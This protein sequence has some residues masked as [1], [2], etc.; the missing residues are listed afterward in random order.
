MKIDSCGKKMD[1]PK[2]EPIF[3][4]R[5]KDNHSYMAIQAMAKVY[6]LDSTILGQF[7]DWRRKHADEC[8]DP[9]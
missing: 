7:T 4:I 2:G 1:I 8:Q 6:N 5:A 3:V 9:D